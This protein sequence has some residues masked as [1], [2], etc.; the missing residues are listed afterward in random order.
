MQEKYPNICEKLI[1]LNQKMKLTGPASIL[2][3]L[4]KE[5]SHLKA[6]LRSLRRRVAVN[7]RRSI[8]LAREYENSIGNSGLGCARYLQDAILKEV[9]SE[10]A[11]PVG[12]EEM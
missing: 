2:S 7:L 12:E 11:N 9:K 3:E 4:L 1:D 6:T 8:D 10:E 5:S